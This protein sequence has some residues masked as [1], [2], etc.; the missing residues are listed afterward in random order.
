M[1][2]SVNTY[3]LSSTQHAPNNKTLPVLHYKNVL[4]QPLTEET[5]TSFMTAH[6]WEKRVS[7][8]FHL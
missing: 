8:D 4:P 3:F 6:K 7:M 5:V 1:M 2:E